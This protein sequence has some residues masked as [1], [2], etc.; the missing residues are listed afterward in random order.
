VQASVTQ[1]D[2]IMEREPGEPLPNARHELFAQLV[3]EGRTLTSAH[4]EAGFTDNRSNASSLR[5]NNAIGQRIKELQVQAAERV[6]VSIERV[7][8]ELAKI[9]FANIGDY[10][11]VSGADGP[12]IDLSALPPEKL[13]AI[14]EIQTETILDRSVRDDESGR[15]GEVRKVRLKLWDKRG[16][17]V[18]LGRPA[19][20]RKESCA[21]AY[22]ELE[23]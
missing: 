6:G 15:T 5:Q 1:I 22:F 21:N 10:V 13:A 19:P 8:N 17:L 2:F 3:A 7:L 9:G 20:I 14:S 4:V 23:S 18:D 16:A 11:D 12:Q